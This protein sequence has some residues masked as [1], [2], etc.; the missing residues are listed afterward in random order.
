MVMKD[1]KRNTGAVQA[2][3]TEELRDTL[4]LALGYIGSSDR[5]D[6]QVHV[7]RIRAMLEAAP[8][9]E[10]LCPNGEPWDPNPDGIRP[11]DERGPRTDPG[12]GMWE[13]VPD[14]AAPSDAGAG[15]DMSD[16]EWL[17]VFERV[18]KTVPN[19][20][21]GYMKVRAEFAREAMRI[22]NQARANAEQAVQPDTRSAGENGRGAIYL[23]ALIAQ[24]THA[25][26]FRTVAEYR[27]AL[28]KSTHP[29]DFYAD[30]TP[31]W[32][33]DVPSFPTLE[34]MRW[35]GVEVADWIEANIKP[36]FD[37]LTAQLAAARMASMADNAQ[38]AAPR[39]LDVAWLGQQ[40]LLGDDFA[41]LFAFHSQCED[42]E[43]DG[44]TLSTATMMRLAEL[45]VVQRWSG[46][47]QRYGVTAFGSW[48]VDAQLAKEQTLPLRTTDEHNE[49][50]TAGHALYLKECAP[51]SVSWLELPR[52]ERE[53]WR[54]RATDMSGQPASL[55]GDMQ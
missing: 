16:R 43:C 22:A 11:G 32:Y 12:T 5:S 20:F 53:S 9:N 39:V 2:P 24:D 21:G 40:F 3:T 13:G 36:A 54:Q 34:S 44:Y 41:A 8:G 25:E 38:S 30:E 19:V 47:S 55:E 23:R 10:P 33:C 7:A 46:R 6:R 48:L 17:E 14:E 1:T 15:F 18:E 52:G 35:R 28:L 37:R 27:D 45:G 26:A 49:R 4:R 50:E 51:R 31:H 29:V 42:S